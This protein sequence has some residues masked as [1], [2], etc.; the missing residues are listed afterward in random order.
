MTEVVCA[1][2]INTEGLIFAARRA[3]DKSFAGYWEFPGGKLEA[4]ERALDALEREISEELSVSIEDAIALHTVEWENKAGAFRLEA[5]VCKSD[6]NGLELKAHDQWAWF[7]LEDLLEL[8]M[9]VA[10]LAFLPYLERF[11]EEGN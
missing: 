7:N 4:G 1:I 11:L 5:F 3:P 8:E 6:L 9:M 10:D 2:I